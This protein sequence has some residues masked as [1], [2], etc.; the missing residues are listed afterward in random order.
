MSQISAT[1]QTKINLAARVSTLERGNNKLQF[2]LHSTNRYERR[3]TLVL[4][5]SDRPIHSEDEN[6]KAL[7]QSLLRSGIKGTVQ[8]KN[9]SYSFNYEKNLHT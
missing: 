9:K 6:P 1:E 2:N 8:E 7:I 5:G 4:S 3:D